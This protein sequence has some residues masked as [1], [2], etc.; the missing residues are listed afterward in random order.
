MALETGTYINSLNPANPAG[1]DA[2][3]QGDDH[4][5]LIKSTIVNTFPNIN[6]AVTVTDEQLNSIGGAGVLAFPGMIVMWSGTVATIPAGWKLCNGV[7]TISTGAPVPN[8]VGRF[9][10]GSA[11]D[12]GSTYDIGD[13]GGSANFTYS[14]ITGETNPAFTVPTT[15]Y[16]ITGISP[17]PGQPTVLGGLIGGRGVVENVEVLESLSSLTSTGPTVNINHSH[18]V[19]ISVANGRLPPYYALAFLI[20]N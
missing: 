1:T 18:T 15:G 4:I 10:V 7:G 17:S 5:R 9:I 13:T 12:S 6:N 8:L 16:N 3:S 11:T 2:R 14:G 19:N 20:K